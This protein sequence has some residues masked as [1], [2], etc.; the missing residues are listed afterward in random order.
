M[1]SHKTLSNFFVIGILVFLLLNT[2]SLGLTQNKSTGSRQ[3]PI[4]SIFGVYGEN[5]WY[6]TAVTISFEYDP[7]KVLEIQYKLSNVWYIYSGPVNIANDGVYMIP[8]FWVDAENKTYYGAPFEFKIDKTAPIIELTKKIKGKEEII[9]T[10]EAVD[11]VSAI[12]RVEFYLDDELIQTDDEAPYQ[13][14][15]EGHITQVVY[16]KTYNYAGFEAKSDNLTTQPRIRFRNHNLMSIIFVLIQKT[17]F[18]FN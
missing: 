14:T 10:A 8:W 13:Y 7:N 2:S 9:F 12:E 17:F 1:V 4:P 6:I 18:R 11:A 16:A 5:Q 3:E 15:W